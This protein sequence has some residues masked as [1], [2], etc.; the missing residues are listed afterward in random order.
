MINF[1]DVTKVGCKG[2]GKDMWVPLTDP[3]PWFCGQKCREW[4]QLNHAEIGKG[5]EEAV[6][7]GS[8]GSAV[9]EV[10]L[11]SPSRRLLS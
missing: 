5:N 4:F 8:S 1:I 2:C 7:D 9:E 11:L 3:G 6:T 10:D